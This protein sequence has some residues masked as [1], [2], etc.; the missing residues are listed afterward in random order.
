[1]CERLRVEVIKRWQCSR[2]AV[3]ARGCTVRRGDVTELNVEVLGTKT[4]W[5]QKKGKHNTVK[6]NYAKFCIF[7]KQ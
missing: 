3:V 6:G 4:R 2:S 5:I 1:M 7:L